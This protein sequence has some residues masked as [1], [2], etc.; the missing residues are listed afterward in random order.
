MDIADRRGLAAEAERRARA[1][2]APAAICAALGLSLTTYRRWAALF[3]FRLCDLD[4]EHPLAR[5]GS[6]ARSYP[7]GRFMLQQ[8]LGGR[9]PGSGRPP[10][11]DLVREG[12]DAP[13]DLLR[14][15]RDALEA[16]ETGLADRL[17]AAW[18]AGNRREAGLAALEAAA[19]A[20]LAD[21]SLPEGW[22]P[23][24]TVSLAQLS[25]MGDY[26]LYVHLCGLRGEQPLAESEWGGFSDG[27]G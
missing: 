20:E 8:G 22:A 3:G 2:E 23:G 12:L 26:E 5:K 14:A 21:E 11:V 17:L 18:K 15:V 6:E 24:D 9:V 13:G 4:P 10:Q 25:A 7:S 19:A 1:G 27:E 16:G